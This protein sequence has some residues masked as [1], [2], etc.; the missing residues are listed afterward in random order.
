MSEQKIREIKDRICEGLK[1]PYEKL[2][3][4]KVVCAFFHTHTPLTFCTDLAYRF[5]GPSEEDIEFAKSSG[6]PGIVYDF[7]APRIRSGHSLMEP[8]KLY[9]FGDARRKNPLHF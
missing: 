3:R 4:R 5:T 2:L 8:A 9:T 1:I 6:L 7:L